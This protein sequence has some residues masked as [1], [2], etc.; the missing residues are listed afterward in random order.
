M[1]KLFQSTMD[2]QTNGI[3]VGSMV[4]DIIAEIILKSVDVELTKLIRSKGVENDVIITRYR[5]D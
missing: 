4:S 1:D 3:P 2:G 5:D